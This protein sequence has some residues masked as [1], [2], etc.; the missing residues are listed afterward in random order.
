M[1]F[2]PTSRR[3][4]RLNWRLAENGIQKAERSMPSSV[5]MVP[6]MSLSIEAVAREGNAVPHTSLSQSPFQSFWNRPLIVAT[7]IA[8]LVAAE[9]QCCANE[10]PVRADRQLRT[11]ERQSARNWRS[12]IKTT[13]G[14]CCFYP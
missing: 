10:K 12:C 14:G 3:G 6:M 4:E 5:S 11:D 7:E 9:L 8:S 13:P 2:A 1:S